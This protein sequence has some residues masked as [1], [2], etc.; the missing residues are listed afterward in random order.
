[1]KEK[2]NAKNEIKEERKLGK[3][4]NILKVKQRST[5]QQQNT[6][7]KT[8]KTRA[9]QRESNKTYPLEKYIT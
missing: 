2:E 4:E 1:M 9:S 5:E 6:I 7:K 3:E 8:M